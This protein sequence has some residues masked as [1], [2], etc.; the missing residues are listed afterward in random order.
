MGMKYL[1]YDKETGYWRRR[2]DSVP[3]RELRHLSNEAYEYSIEEHENR[4][5]VFCMRRVEPEDWIG[6]GISQGQALNLQSLD[7]EAAVR[8]I[9]RMFYAEFIFL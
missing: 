8:E 1:Y 7:K 4:Y 6:I 2:K 5:F 3:A 9:R